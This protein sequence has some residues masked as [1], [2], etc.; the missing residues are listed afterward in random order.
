MTTSAGTDL[1]SLRAEIDQ[2]DD[3]IID[4]LAR[5]FAIVRE[6]AHYKQQHGVA[7]RLPERIEQVK[8]RCAARGA[9]RGLDPEFVRA[10][11]SGLIEQTCLVEERILADPV[12]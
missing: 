7:V 12:P 5:R 3:Q 6:V 1:S 2:I 11:Y 9:S 8:T 4:L 10:L